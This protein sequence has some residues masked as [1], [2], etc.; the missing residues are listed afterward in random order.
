MRIINST[1]DF[2]C[3]SEPGKSQRG[4]EQQRY[5]VHDDESISLNVLSRA[6]D[7]GVT[8][9]ATLNYDKHWRP[10]D[11]YVRFHLGDRVEGSAWFRFNDNH[12]VADIV[13]RD[14]KYR[15]ETLDYPAPSQRIAFCAHP[16]ATDAALMSAFD[17][18]LEYNT[19]HLEN[20]YLSSGHHFGAVGPELAKAELEIEYLGTEKLNKAG[21]VFETDHWRVH[22]GNE[23]TGHQHPGEDVWVLKD[24]FVFIHAEINKLGYSYELSSFEES[25]ISR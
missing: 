18:S 23:N 14:G 2:F 17:P 22:S 1:V 11:S 16:I 25:I 12:V 5:V 21:R 10:I 15:Q 6:F 3:V 19:Q 8:R 24:S 13:D 20:I 9:E 7:H 4:F